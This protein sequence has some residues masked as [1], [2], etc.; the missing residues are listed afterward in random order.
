MLEIWNSQKE[1]LCMKYSAKQMGNHY[2]NHNWNSITSPKIT[3][4][5][6]IPQE[7]HC[8]IWND[9]IINVSFT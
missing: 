3:A 1:V 4:L 7:E 8:W 6:S 9:F 5:A 2:K